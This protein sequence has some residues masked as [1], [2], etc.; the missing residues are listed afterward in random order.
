MQLNS[1]KKN[2]LQSEF[3][4]GTATQQFCVLTSPFKAQW[5]DRSKKKINQLTVQKCQDFAD[6]HALLANNT[7]ITL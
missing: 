1:A 7:H 6:K 4:K 2:N 3:D 5:R